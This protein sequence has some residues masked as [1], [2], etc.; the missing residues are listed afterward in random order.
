[1]PA[2]DRS[3]VEDGTLPLIDHDVRNVKLD[4][5]SAELLAIK[6]DIMRS[7]RAVKVMTGEEAVKV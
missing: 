5:K 4:N 1:L 3:T 6:K 2:D 7:R